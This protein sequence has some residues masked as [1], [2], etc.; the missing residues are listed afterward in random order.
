[1]GI[2]AYLLLRFSKHVDLI[3]ADLPPWVGVAV[4]PWLSYVLTF[5]AGVLVHRAI[6]AELKRSK[7]PDRITLIELRDAAKKQR[8]DF[9]DTSYQV[10]DLATSLR[11]SAL[12][13]EITVYGRTGK[14]ALREYW[15]PLRPIPADQWQRINIDASALVDGRNGNAMA[16]EVNPTVTAYDVMY[17]VTYFDLQL[18]R[19]AAMEWLKHTAIKERGNRRIMEEESEKRRGKP[20]GRMA[21]EMEATPDTLPKPR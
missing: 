5:A 9:S 12:L 15:E 19:E 8:W 13:G 7:R 11:Q 16:Y 1:L 20:T 2:A 17:S 10:F 21:R 3:L 4:G 6:Q 14:Q 18:D